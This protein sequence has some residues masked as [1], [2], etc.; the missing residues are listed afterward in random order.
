MH[1]EVTFE[2]VNS[3]GKLKNE[4][5]E[6]DRV[7][8]SLIDIKRCPYYL[9]SFYQ[10]YI[11]NSFIASIYRKSLIK[12]T[13][14][15]IMRFNGSVIGI[16]PLL[17]DRLK[18]RVTILDGKVA[19][20]LNVVSPLICRSGI[21]GYM[22]DLIIFIREHYYNLKLSFH[23]IPCR[24][25]FFK[26]LRGNG[27]EKIRG[28]YHI[29]LSE[30]GS[31]TIYFK[32][33]GKNVRQNIRTAYNRIKNDNR[34]LTLKIYDKTN[35][36]S[37]LLLLR[38]WTIYYKRKNAW[39]HRKTNSLHDS[40]C[41]LRALKEIC[42]GIKN[43]SI[44]DV[45]NCRLIV[46]M[47]DG[48]PVAFMQTYFYLSHVLVPKLAIDSRFARYSPGYLLLMETFKYLFAQGITDIDLCRGDEE[49]K[50]RVGGIN[51]PIGKVYIA[52]KLNL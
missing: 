42:G 47:V 44:T 49:Y 13:D 43:R 9:Y 25:P 4:W 5:T 6:I 3:I 37:S 48:S 11:W 10:T 38:L 51:E 39:K 16:L 50:K 19:G 24:S 52:S 40:V 18:G 23:S 28:S 36:P 12:R 29:P 20:I 7:A 45:E 14:F 8:A 31:F 21:E 46:L 32:S 15:I 33:L 41:G 2:I 22:D 30:F 26:A 1:K 35:P 34:V 17:V 27:N